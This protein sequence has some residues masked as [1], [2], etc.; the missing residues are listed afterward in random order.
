MTSGERTFGD[1]S[2]KTFM[3]IGGAVAAVAAGI[4]PLAI[5]QDGGGAVDRNCAHNSDQ[6]AGRSGLLVDPKGAYV[7]GAQN[8]GG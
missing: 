8:F 6:N 2:T 1:D 5:G 4:A 7:V 3:W